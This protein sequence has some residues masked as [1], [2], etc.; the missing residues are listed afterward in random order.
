MRLRRDLTVEFSKASAI[1]EPDVIRSKSNDNCKN[2]DNCK[3]SSNCSG[4][5]GSRL[6]ACPPV[7]IG[8]HESQPAIP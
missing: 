7:L 6:G 1:Y 2:N 8:I 4:K 5:T 3:S